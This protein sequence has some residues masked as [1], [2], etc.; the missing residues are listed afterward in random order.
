[1]IGAFIQ[2]NADS[3]N[4]MSL[5]YPIGYVITERGCHEW[6]GGTNGNGYGVLLYQGKMVLA[7]IYFWEQKNGPVPEG[8]ELDH[9]YC[10]NRLC[11]N[12]EHVRPVSRRE[13]Q[14]RSNSC[15][16]LCRSKDFCPKGHPLSGD[17][18]V[19]SHLKIGGRK[20]RTCKNR[21]DMDRY[22]RNRY[23]MVP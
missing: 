10:D 11:C 12:E 18:L 22:Y 8:L 6:V 19:A 17:N 15:S 1:M 16:S 21:R 4:G 9:F 3:R 20:C 7:H 5:K 14:L 13:N 2:L 23:G